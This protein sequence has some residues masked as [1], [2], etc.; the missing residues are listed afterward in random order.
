[1]VARVDDNPASLD[2]HFGDNM[3]RAA[4]WGQQKQTSHQQIILS[5]EIQEGIRRRST[6]RN[7]CW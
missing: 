2:E 6:P 7:S 1:V 3:L 5:R 4:V